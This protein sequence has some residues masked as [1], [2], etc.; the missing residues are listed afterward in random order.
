MRLKIASRSS[1][2]AR[3]QAFQ[4]ARTLKKMDASIE[5]EHE[6]R[7]SL[8]DQN[9]DVPL[10]S[11]GSKGVFT[12]D[13]FEDLKARK[14]DMVVH[15]WKD[16]P[17]ESREG[18]TVAATLPR[19]DVRDLILI[20]KE[21]WD[22]T[23]GRLTL[24]SSSPRRSY[25]LKNFAVYF[26]KKIDIEFK[27]VRGNVPTR[28]EKMFSEKAGLILAKAAV[29]RLLSAPEA[30][31]SSTQKQLRARLNDCRFVVLPLSINPPAAAQGA[32]AI[33]IHAQNAELAA[34]LKKINHHE[35][36]EDVQWERSTL[37]SYGG[38]C[39][40]KIGV[41]RISKPS[42]EWSLLK[43]LTDQG[44]RLDTDR[45]ISKQPALPRASKKTAVF[46]LA[47]KENN[48]FDRR[49]LEAAEPKTSALW[50]AKADAWPENLRYDG[51][52]W[53]SGLSSWK[54]LAAKGVWVNGCS[55]NLG[56][57]EPR[58]E[59]LAPHLQWTKLTHKEAATQAKGTALATYELIPKPTEQSPNLRGKTHFFWLSASSFK[60][61]Y[62]LFPQDL[63]AGHH[64][65]GPGLTYEFLSAQKLT[66]P[67]KIFLSLD[68]FLNEVLPP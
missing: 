29:D 45:W 2:L 18:T 65:C 11:W 42:S 58:L 23:E 20:P 27:N 5:I 35:T 8:G 59:Q 19:A 60:R 63:Q 40:Q 41:L 57:E 51:V 28:I 9:L 38:G 52:V 7:S 34:L 15:S 39:H 21:V 30:E 55:E 33:E 46:P 68:A 53:A 37:K 48:W 17:T 47:T 10:A 4:V 24:L 26:P 44:E 64:G 14:F 56:E 67:P 54:K 13:F 43:G 31:F 6:F 66:H 16:L 50:V 3:I 49:P 25:N 1:D 62:E 32:L 22:R 36:F 61:A 12:Q